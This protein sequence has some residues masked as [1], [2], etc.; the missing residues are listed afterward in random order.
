MPHC[1]TGKAELYYEEKGEGKPIVLIHGYTIDH[2]LMS[3]CMEPVFRER[4]GWRRVYLD[5]PGMGKTRGYSEIE[6]SDEML[7]AVLALI[8]SM[9]PGE[10]FAL[11]GESYGGYIARGIIA[12][13]PERVNGAALI[14]PMIIPEK[15]DRTLPPHTII[16]QDASLAERLTPEELADF[17]SIGVVL[18]PYTWS[19]YKEEIV[20]GCLLADELFLAKIKARYGF[21]FPVDREEFRKP[22]VLLAGRQDSSTGY[23]DAFSILKMYPRTTFAVLDRAGHNLQI[24]QPRLFE[25]LIMEWLDRVEEEAGQ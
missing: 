11:A 16:R 15:Q 8:D 3:G 7:E 1:Q 12:K 20:P 14:C 18:N 21:S 23:E 24:E 10:S 19:R 4:A 17:A 6:N 2:R 22:G 25:N 9:L 5:L 13:M